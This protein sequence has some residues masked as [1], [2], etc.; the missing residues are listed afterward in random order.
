MTRKSRG[1]PP[2]KAGRKK[3][4]LRPPSPAAGAGAPIAPLAAATAIETQPKPASSPARE[5]KAASPPLPAADRR[6]LMSELRLIGILS[7]GFIALLLALAF[8]LR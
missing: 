3:R 4:Q 7:G 5:A 2:S 1:G 6:Y 8:F